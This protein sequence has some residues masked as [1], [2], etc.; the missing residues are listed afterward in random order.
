[1]IP[2]PLGSLPFVVVLVVVNVVCCL[3]KPDVASCTFTVWGDPPRS[4]IA[5][6]EKNVLFMDGGVLV[7]ADG[8]RRQLVFR[9]PNDPAKCEHEN[10]VICQP[11]KRISMLMRQSP[12]QAN[13]V[14]RCSAVP[15]V[16]N[17]D[18]IGESF[19]GTMV[20][21]VLHSLHRKP[22]DAV[23]I[24]AGAGRITS[25]LL[26]RVEGIKVTAV[27]IDPAV[28]G[29]SE[30]FGLSASKDHLDLTVVDGRRWL[31]NKKA[32]SLDAIFLD[33]FDHSQEIP[34]CLTTTEFYAVVREKLRPGGVVAVNFW[35]K[36]RSSIIPIFAATFGP[37]G[38]QV[39]TPPGLGNIIAIGK[40]EEATS[41]N[42]TSLRQTHVTKEV[43]ALWSNSHFEPYTVP[44]PGTFVLRSD[45][46]WCAGHGV[47]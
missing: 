23:V 2:Q 28:I 24:G 3:A 6:P 11:S 20:G 4:L 16:P 7:V 39:G 17:V 45:Q 33:T 14:D 32:S 34:S 25:W 12:L 1:M 35:P 44:A 46:S 47:V 27:D 18:G 26:A 36:H 29:A 9:S 43:Q 38:I 10:E 13:S 21:G 40:R 30:C 8:P 31:E 15:C 19:A 41:G 37:E 22:H 42:S 5:D